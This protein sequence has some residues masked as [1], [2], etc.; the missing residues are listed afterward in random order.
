MNVY[1]VYFCG[2]HDCVSVRVCVCVSHMYVPIR[3]YICIYVVYMG[4]TTIG[5]IYSFSMYMN[6]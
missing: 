3:V 5:A 1:I 6:M 4:D 2:I